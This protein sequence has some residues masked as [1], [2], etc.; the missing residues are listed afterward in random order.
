MS[1]YG[2]YL[3]LHR[4]P[5]DSHGVHSHGAKQGFAVAVRDIEANTWEGRER[6]GGVGAEARRAEPAYIWGLRI[7]IQIKAAEPLLD[8][9]GI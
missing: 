3:L 4:Q 5:A 1:G 8:D 6:L 2:D 7:S 9:P